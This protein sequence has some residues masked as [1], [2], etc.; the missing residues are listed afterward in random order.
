MHSPKTVQKACLKWEEKTY[1]R[2]KMGRKYNLLTSYYL[3]S[4]CLLPQTI[5]K[6]HDIIY[7]HTGEKE[8]RLIF[9]FALWKCIF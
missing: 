7:N 8:G 6:Y 9:G 1:Y 4:E 3:S 2:R 5:Q